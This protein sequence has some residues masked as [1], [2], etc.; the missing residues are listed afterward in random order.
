MGWLIS[1][2]RGPPERTSPP[3]F[4]ICRL[5]VI[6]VSIVGSDPFHLFDPLVKN[7]VQFRGMNLI[8]S[9]MTTLRMSSTSL[10]ARS[11]KD[12]LI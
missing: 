1:S 11:A 8:Q 12:G 6:V 9:S 5:L 2:G 4:R 10:N 3:E 7:K